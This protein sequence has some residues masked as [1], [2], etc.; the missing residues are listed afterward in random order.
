MDSLDEKAFEQ[1]EF[2]PYHYS[3]GQKIVGC[4]ITFVAVVLIVIAL[5]TLF[6]NI[7]ENLTK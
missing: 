5:V 3:T 2:C 4:A 1:D 6:A 7:I